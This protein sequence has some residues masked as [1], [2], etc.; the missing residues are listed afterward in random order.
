MYK[1]F[2]KYGIENF[3]I[4]EIEQCSNEEL[5]N[6]EIYWINFFNSYKARKGY[7]CTS[8]GEGGIKTYEED[9]D[10]IIQRYLKG[11]RLDLLCKEFHHDYSC[12]RPK[13]IER[14]VII[15]T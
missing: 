3:T 15:N 10:L 9:I 12:L 4:E 1:A 13:L 14:G 2:N 7:N 8:G 5:D 6:R 11:E